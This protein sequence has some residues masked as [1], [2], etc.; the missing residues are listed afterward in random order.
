MTTS[1]VFR[2]TRWAFALAAALEGM[3]MLVYPGGTPL[4]SETRGYSFFQNS[5]SDLGSTVARNGEANPGY[6]IHIAAAL[7]LVV[8]G[9]ATYGAL[10]RVY[11]SAPVTRRL[12]RAAGALVLLAAAGLLGAALTPPDLHAAF[13]RQFTLLA[14]GSFPL[15]T[16]LLTLATALGPGV[17]RRVPVSWLLLTLI[18]VAWA[19]MMLTARPTTDL[20]LAIPVTLQKITGV[21]LVATLVFQGWEAERRGAAVDGTR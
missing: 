10:I 9:G 13:H 18:V 15:A 14:V 3:A 6:L 20:A 4:R 7:I 8:A 12:A 5:L 17:R 2:L 19:S 11:E 1:T 21:T 16:A